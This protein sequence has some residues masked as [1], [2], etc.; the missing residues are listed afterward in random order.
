M[1]MYAEAANRAEGGPNP[2]AIMYLNMIR[3]RAKLLPVVSATQD[4][5]E[6][7]IWAERYFELAYENKMWFDMLRTRMVRNDLTR[8]WENFVGH[9][10]VYR[11]TFTDSQLL[12]PIPQREIDNN[13]NL[14]QNPGFN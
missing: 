12:F 6:K 2:N 1:L 13:K 7:A 14:V 3:A 11:K 5:F 9:T 10:T 8:Q 4:E